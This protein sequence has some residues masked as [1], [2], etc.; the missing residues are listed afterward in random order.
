MGA[1]EGYDALRS[2]DT[3]DCRLGYEP[4]GSSS[5]PVDFIAFPRA[6]PANKGKNRPILHASCT[7][8]LAHPDSN[9]LESWGLPQFNGTS[10]WQ[11]MENRFDFDGSPMVPGDAIRMTDMMIDAGFLGRWTCARILGLRNQ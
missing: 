4:K 7:L 2:S 1:S 3:C 6:N 9:A 10:T 11:E 5:S 8:N